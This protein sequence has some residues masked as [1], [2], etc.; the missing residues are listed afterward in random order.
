MLG[1][2]RHGVENKKELK[3]ESLSILNPIAAKMERKGLSGEQ[4]NAIRL[5]PNAKRHC[6]E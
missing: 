1:G 6:S 5:A 3:G 2:K 4:N